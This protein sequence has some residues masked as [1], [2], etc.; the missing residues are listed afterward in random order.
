[1]DKNVNGKGVITIT[2]WEL[3][4]KENINIDVI[5]KV[6]L[7]ITKIGLLESEAEGKD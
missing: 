3:M 4:Q 5:E 7:I 2:K 6:V 1:M